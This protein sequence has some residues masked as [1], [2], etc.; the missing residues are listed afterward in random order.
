MRLWT[1]TATFG[2]ALSIGASPAS[3]GNADSALLGNQAALAG[4]AV[5]AVANDAGATWYNPAGLAFL[6]HG[7]VS[8]TATAL[9]LRTYAMRSSLQVILPEGN[10]SFDLSHSEIAASPTSIVA[11][12]KLSPALTAAG[13]LFLR[14]QGA[15]QQVWAQI[16]S[17]ANGVLSDGSTYTYAQRLAVQQKGYAIH[18]GPSVA[19]RLTPAIN[20]GA[21]LFLVYEGTR[22]FTEIFSDLSSDPNGAFRTGLMS[23][24]TRSSSMLASEAVLGAQWRISPEWQAGAVLRTPI[25][26]LAY[27]FHSDSLDAH[28]VDGGW[29]LPVQTRNDGS[30]GWLLSSLAPPRLHLGIARLFGWGFV[31]LEGNVSPTKPATDLL[32]GQQA[33]WNLRLGARRDLS[34]TLS[35]G[36]GVFTD[37]TPGRTIDRFAEGRI[38]YYGVTAGIELRKPFTLRGDSAQSTVVV[39][40]TFALRYELGTGSA[41]RVL[42]DA[43]SNTLSDTPAGPA[44]VNELELYVGSGL[45]F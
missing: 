2:A 4:N 28:T 15:P 1:A 3:A 36:G 31:S 6:E 41:G 33:V 37:R 19:M 22:G 44:L 25:L 8:L 9:G 35:V 30:K 24:F 5:T 39:A 7:S 21:S 23:Q 12:H 40:S 18:A 13:S 29:L 34:D 45:S 20:V 17:A 10:R 11:V 32:P 14:A 27:A 42:L 16:D 38:D 26:L 43:V